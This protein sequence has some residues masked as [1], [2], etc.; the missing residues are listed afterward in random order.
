MATPKKPAAKKAPARKPRPKTTERL[1][2]PE[3]LLQLP[4]TD[5][6]D[7]ILVEQDNPNNFKVVPAFEFKDMRDSHKQ[8]G[9]KFTSAPFLLYSAIRRAGRLQYDEFHFEGLLGEE[10]HGK[11]ILV[12]GLTQF[13]GSYGEA[14]PELK[15][16]HASSC[17]FVVPSSGSGATFGSGSTAAEA[18]AVAISNCKRLV[19][20]EF[21]FA[22]DQ[23]HC[24]GG[25]SEKLPIVFDVGF[26]TIY[27]RALPQFM[28]AIGFPAFE[29]K[30]AYG[31]IALIQCSKSLH[32]EA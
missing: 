19:A 23:V 10:K 28:V 18:N 6:T 14:F 5:A 22:M 13:S 27:T 16:E 4:D 20:T 24:P 17:P 25:C 12:N 8:F 1:L 30:V 32:P 11:P 7:Y 31:W 3:K 21:D 2:V 29:S 9:V 15:T 26:N